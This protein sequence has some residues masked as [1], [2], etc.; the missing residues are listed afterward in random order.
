[1]SLLH[2]PQFPTGRDFSSQC[3]VLLSPD[4][5]NRSPYRLGTIPPVMWIRCNT[6]RIRPGKPP[7]GNEKLMRLLA[8]TVFFV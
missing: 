1:M 2:G 7:Y 5:G 8:E 3:L 6:H 4:V